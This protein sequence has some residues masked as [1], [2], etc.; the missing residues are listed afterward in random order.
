[1]AFTNIISGTIGGSGNIISTHESFKSNLSKFQV[2]YNGT[3]SWLECSNTA[4]ITNKSNCSFEIKL[5]DGQTLTNMGIMFHSCSSLTSL[6]LSNF[7]TSSITNMYYMF[8]NCSSLT[9]LDLSNFDVIKVAS[10]ENM[11]YGCSS[12]TSLDL[13]SFNTS[14]LTN[15]DSMFA[16]CSSLTSLDLSNFN[17]NKVTNMNNMFRECPVSDIRLLY[18][19]SSTINSL[20]PHLGASPARN[21]YYLNAP[22]SELEVRGNI[23]YKKAAVKVVAKYKFDSS[24]YTDYLPVFNSEFTG[25]TK[26]DVNNGDGTITRT[27]GHMTLKPTLMRF[28]GAINTSTDREKSLLEVMECDTSN[29]TDMHTMF[30]GCRNLISLDASN[31]DTSKVTNMFFAFNGCLSLAS[32]NLSSFDTSKVTNM[33]SMFEDCSALTSLNVSNWDTSN[34]TDMAYMFNNCKSL[35]S[36]DLSSFNTGKVTNMTKIFHG[37]SKLTSLVLSNFN[38]SKV[39]NMTNMFSNCSSLTTLDVSNFNTSKVTAMREMFS[40]CSSLTSLNVS[41]FDTGNVTNMYCMFNKCSSLTTLDLSNFDTS[42]VTNM[43]SMFENCSSL[44]SLDVSNFNTNEATTIRY[45]FYGCS[46][47]T[48]LDLSNFNTSKVTNMSWM[49]NG[50]SKLTTLDLSN[51]N[52][53][54]VTSMEYMLSSCTASDI[55]LLYASSSTIN[56]LLAQ[57]GTTTA[58]NI[59]YTDAPLNELTVQ[60]N[61]TYK[62]Y[63]LKQATFPYTLNKLPNGVADYIDVVNK[64]HVQRVRKVILNGNES[65]SIVS[66]TFSDGLVFQIALSPKA[67]SDNSIMCDKLEVKKIWGDNTGQGIAI[68]STLTHLQIK[69]AIIKTVDEFKIWLASNPITVIYGIETPIYTPLTEEEIAQ[70]PLSAYKDGYVMLSSDQLTPSFEFRMRASNRYQVDMLETGYYYLNAPVGNVKLGTA[71]VDVQQMPC[72]VKVD[73]VGTGD[74]GYRLTTSATG[75]VN[76]TIPQSDMVDGA[77]FDSTN[78]AFTANSN[79]CYSPNY[80]DILPNTMYGIIA[81]TNMRINLFT[82]NQSFI[83]TIEA[84]GNGIWTPFT[85][86]SNAKLFRLSYNKIAKKDHV[87]IANPI[88][89]AKL[90]SH[91]IPTSFTQGMKSSVD[92]GYWEGIRNAKPY[93]FR[94]RAT[95]GAS[96]EEQS[97]TNIPE[98]NRIEYNNTI[99]EDEFDIATGKF[100]KRIEKVILDGI[101]H[102]FEISYNNNNPKTILVDTR[103]GMINTLPKLGKAMGL[104]LSDRIASREGYNQS[105]EG[106]DFHSNSIGG[107]HFSL[108]RTRL[109]RYDKQ[110]VVD[111]LQQNPLTIYY[112]LAVPEISYISLS[113]NQIKTTTD[114]TLVQ[115]S[116]YNELYLNPQVKPSHLTYPVPSLVGN[117]TY[118]VV[119][120][121]KNIT[122]S[123]KPIELNLGGTLV[124]LN[125]ASSKTLVKTPSTLA[126]SN[127]I[128][129]GGEST[130]DHIMVLDGDWTNKP[131]EYFENMKGHD[132]DAIITI[133]G[134]S[135][136]DDVAEQYLW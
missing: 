13:S 20:L 113:A 69:H 10:M 16:N 122:G 3:G 58:R 56:S 99:V 109:G 34:V 81:P 134:D 85:T 84:L 54:K 68:N 132:T 25:Y 5:K 105:V 116:K 41:S 106:I 107:L 42:Q 136:I 98:L 57:L 26:T 93:S 65:W 11:F 87:L 103:S 35:T 121:R 53:S 9:S 120:N 95:G 46:K 108:Y 49:F 119:H 91:R 18:A 1:M 67:I 71:N 2:R 40:G 50:C 114:S 79:M 29:V 43:N 63:E 4:N 38:T 102:D 22:L 83:K 75:G 96:V 88:T 23:T 33:N 7:D 104:V 125:D 124:Q 52:T 70:L 129:I 17:T 15:T 123:T 80:Y 90:P 76:I 14:S 12:L 128:F 48:T 47:L 94:T 61:I 97:L 77:Y 24:L 51:F 117:R 101:N 36:L 127:L 110:G 28:G 89:L 78:G 112:E 130:V 82:E 8:H 19:S 62:K 66:T 21:I 135:K 59:Y 37:C 115:S 118:T 73:N 30:S 72:I 27:I 39:E 133:I 6:N 60:D 111:Y 55:G 131:I 86:P 64:V 31:F 92:F 44:T 74:S 126:H 32:L 45:M 100:I